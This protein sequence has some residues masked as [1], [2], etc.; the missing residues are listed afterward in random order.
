MY[1]PE[2]RTTDNTVSFY[3]WVRDNRP[4]LIKSRCSDS[5]WALKRDLREHTN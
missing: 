4:E 1:S 2:K 5:F 3:G